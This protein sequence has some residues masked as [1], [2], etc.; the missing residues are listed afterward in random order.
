MFGFRLIKWEEEY[1]PCDSCFRA[2]K[3]RECFDN[4]LTIGKSMKVPSKCCVCERIVACRKCGM[5]LKAKNGISTGKNAYETSKDS[6][7]FSIKM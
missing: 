2:F 3:S 5:D 7:M 1:L 4:H 6:F